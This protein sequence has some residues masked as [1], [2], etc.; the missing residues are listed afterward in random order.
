MCFLDVWVC[1]RCAAEADGRAARRCGHCKH[2]APELARVG[3]AL[4]AAKTSLVAVGKVNADAHRDLGGRFEVKGY[5]TLKWFPKGS[6]T[7]ED[8]SGGRTAEDIVGFLNSKTG[9]KLFIPKAVSA[10]V[11]GTPADFD[12]LVGDQTGK[13]RLVELFAPW[14]GHCKALAPVYEKLAAVFAADADK[15][16][17]AKVDAD[18]HKDLGQRFNVQGFPT[19]VFMPRGEPASKHEPYNGGRD[20][21][22]FV[23][24][25][26]DKCGTQRTEEGRLNAQAGRVASIDNSIRAAADDPDLQKTEAVALVMGAE[27]EYYL[28]V[29]RNIRAK[30]DAWVDKEFVR[31]AT[32]IEGSTQAATAT[33]AAAKL[34]DMQRR[35]N[36]LRSFRTHRLGLADD[37]Q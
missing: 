6:T 11:E 21:A 10:V 30:G 24:F 31:L 35:V 36:V 22:G 9:S 37:A 32:I 4:L 18:K 26:N 12:A 17:I 5:P 33:A 27:G 20:L 3:D 16:V 2:L 25:V 19:I 1:E 34:D 28:R 15:V 8:Y 23:S 14:C 7:P 13:C 29:V